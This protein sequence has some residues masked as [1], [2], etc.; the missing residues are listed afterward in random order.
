MSHLSGAEKH[1]L[2]KRLIK[3][4]AFMYVSDMSNMVSR[5]LLVVILAR[6]IGPEQFGL[7]Q[8]VI[9][10]AAF[11]ALFLDFQSNDALI[12][13]LTEYHTIGNYAGVR[14][15]VR[16][17]Y[18]LNA[19][20]GLICFAV[21]LL[22]SPVLAEHLFHD[23]RATLLLCIYSIGV[24][25]GF[26]QTTGSAQLQAFGHFKTIGMVTLCTACF[27][28]IFPLVAI[29]F[30][31]AY[32][33]AGYAA[34]MTLNAMII[35]CT[36]AIKTRPLIGHC[37][38]SPWRA[39]IKK[40]YRFVMFSTIS[41]TFKSI[42]SYID[43]LI[44]G[45]FTSPT[46]VGYYKFALAFT[47]VL[48]IISSPVNNVIYPTLTGLWVRKDYRTYK[49]LLTKL[50]AIKA[51]FL[52]P[53]ALLVVLLAPWIIKLTVTADFLPARYAIY[54]LIWP[55]VLV[56]IFSWTKP[57]LLSWEKPQISTIGN[58]AIVVLM[59]GLAFLLV[60]A[61]GYVG[62]SITYAISYSFGALF[63]LVVVLKL[64]KKYRSSV[65]P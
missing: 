59:L 45:F 30:G 31:L 2:K 41:S 20:L 50:S 53:C 14:T 26:F 17:G 15:L 25:A 38:A 37:N 63:Y 6:I 16:L 44:L 46:E 29:P 33:M 49:R 55:V 19:M 1:T 12:K 13:F 52:I 61:Y 18:M 8:L 35:V 11:I 57:A 34:A 10:S 51:G 64:F 3:D 60:P 32:I 58:F 4:S 9:T 22:I 5:F 48:G 47:S 7:I 40:I 24:I 54:I 39:E 65:S 36:A 56:N 23:E 27:R 43:V 28:V 42:M 21:I 62:A